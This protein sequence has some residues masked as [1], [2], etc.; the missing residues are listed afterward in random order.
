MAPG[1]GIAP[2]AGSG[3]SRRGRITVL[4][5]QQ[6]PLDGEQSCRETLRRSGVWK[7]LHVGPSS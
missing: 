7:T 5:Q 1:D 6:I 4:P 3:R 2:S